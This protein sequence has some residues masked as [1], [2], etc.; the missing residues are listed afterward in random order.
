MTT[1]NREMWRELGIDLE[2]HDLLMNA[3]PSV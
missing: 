3:L 1:D 2:Q